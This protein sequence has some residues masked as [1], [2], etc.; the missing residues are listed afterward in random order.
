MKE[1]TPIEIEDI[2]YSISKIKR[3]EVSPFFKTK[4]IGKLQNQ[5]PVINYSL[6]FYIVSA[7]SLI[8]FFFNANIAKENRKYH[9]NEY[10]FEENISVDPYQL[11]TTNY[12]YE[13]KK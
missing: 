11:N 12:N 1:R 8:L 13:L 3:A 2:I 9:A 6:Y 10:S 5:K 7:A 4:L